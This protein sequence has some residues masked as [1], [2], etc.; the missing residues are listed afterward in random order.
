M[1]NSVTGAALCFLYGCLLIIGLASCSLPKFT[2]AEPTSEPFSPY[3]LTWGDTSHPLQYEQALRHLRAGRYA[4][5]EAKYRQLTELEPNNVNG[6]VGLGSSLQLQGHLDEAR[7]AF[8]LALEISPNS[9]QAHIGLGSAYY[10]LGMFDEARQQYDQ[11]V[12]LES[13]NL[14]ALWG[15]SIALE[16]L[17]RPLEAAD[18]W[19][20]IIQLHPQSDEADW[21]RSKLSEYSVELNVP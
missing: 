18:V 8:E 21:A 16:A 10:R 9:V 13:N 20:R 2:G 17:A 19:E 6:Y 12:T 5:A 4:D 11:A 1:K 15:L 14:D 7:E 3:S